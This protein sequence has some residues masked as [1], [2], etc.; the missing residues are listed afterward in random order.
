MIYGKLLE[1]NNIDAFNAIDENELMNDI[2]NIY[3]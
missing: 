2:K 3:I 1:T